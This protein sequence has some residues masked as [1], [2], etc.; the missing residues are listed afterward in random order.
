[1]DRERLFRDGQAIRRRLGRTGS[2]RPTLQGVPEF[3]QISTELIFGGV[4]AR[5]GLELRYRMLA[6]LST[7]NVLQRLNQLPSYIAGAIALGISPE[8]VQETLLQGAFLAGFPAATSALLVAQDVF[9]RHGLAVG[10]GPTSNDR[11]SDLERR[12]AELR[13]S[14]RMDG[15]EARE[16]PAS[17]VLEALSRLSDQYEFGVLWQRPALD[18]KSRALVG[19]AG[20][21]ALADVELAERYLDASRACGWTP[22]EIQETL[23]QVAPYAGFAPVRK[24]ARLLERPTT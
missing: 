10:P 15:G 14:L 23:L 6:T 7:L 19:L 3:Q 12:G 13:A 17:A 9:E 16:A 2:T 8:E 5:P 1:M 21:T 18:R 20:A 11:L 4:W 22:V 24:V